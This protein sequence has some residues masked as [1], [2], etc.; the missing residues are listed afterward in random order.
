M[1]A[2]IRPDIM[3]NFKAPKDSSFLVLYCYKWLCDHERWHAKEL[4]PV[5]F[6]LRENIVMGLDNEKK[7]FA[8]LNWQTSCYFTID[9]VCLLLS[10]G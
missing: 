3:C 2:K 5:S 7:H 8:T 9:A 4:F 6:G 1:V 10:I